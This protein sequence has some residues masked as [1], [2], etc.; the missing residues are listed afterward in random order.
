MSDE[1]G[2]NGWVNWDTLEA[3]NWI[4]ASN[5]GVYLRAVK[6]AQR[7]HVGAN[8]LKSAFGGRYGYV[9]SC[10]PHIAL[11]RVNWEQIR[12]ALITE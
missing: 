6:I 9:K 4:G 1:N 3:Y 10:D 2:Y 8:T 7:K 5:E 11:T 12:L